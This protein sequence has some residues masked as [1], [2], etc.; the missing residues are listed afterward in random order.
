DLFDAATVETLGRRLIR[1]LEAAVVDAAQPLGSLPILEAAE[2]D[3]ILRTWNDTARELGQPV[4]AATLPA[5][6]AAQA[7]RTPDA[8]AVVLLQGAAVDV[9]PLQDVVSRVLLELEDLS[10][11][12]SALA[13]SALTSVS[14]PSLDDLHADHLAYMIYTSGSTGKPKGAAN[15]HA[16]LHNRL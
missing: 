10:N 1:L 11:E 4:P 6:F 9:L 8:V 16:G 2:R 12:S 14:A 7:V 3:T 5:L 13:S 15:T